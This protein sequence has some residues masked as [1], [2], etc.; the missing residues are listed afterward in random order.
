MGYACNATPN[1]LSLVILW[2]YSLQEL[3]EGGCRYVEDCKPP[4]QL[5][6][7][8]HDIQGMNVTP[9]RNDQIELINDEQVNASLYFTYYTFLRISCFHHGAAVSPPSCGDPFPPNSPL[10]GHIRGYLNSVQFEVAKFYTK[11][12]SDSDVLDDVG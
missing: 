2:H 3:S 12:Y 4:L 7:I 10:A 9:D 1:K 11:P 5:I 8:L 6:G